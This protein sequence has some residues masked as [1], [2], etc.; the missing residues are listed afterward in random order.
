MTDLLLQKEYKAR[1]NR[2]MDYIQTRLD[3]ELTLEELAG[4]ANFSKYHFHRLFYVMT[5]ETLFQF[6]Q[7]LR[8]E[9]AA[10]SLCSEPSKPI[11]VIALDCGFSS[12]ASFAKRFKEYYGIS[13]TQ[14]RKGKGEDHRKEE[15]QI[16]NLDKGESNLRKDDRISSMYVDYRNNKQIW[17]IKME[18]E[19][20]T[21]EIITFP[22]TTVAYVRHVGPYKGDGALFERLFAA[23]FSWAGPRNLIGG[24]DFKTL[25]IYHDNPEIT[26]DNKLRVSVCISVPEDTQVSGEIGKMEIPAGSYAVVPFLLANDEYQSAWDWCYGEWLPRSGYLPDDRPCFELYP[27]PANDTGKT[28][29]DIYIPVK[30]L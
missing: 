21:V 5:G 9:K 11:T 26:E 23:L 22:K 8:M 28:R 15:Q 7:R 13:A 10:Y 12:S 19:E 2:V 30:P 17:R 14:W 3:R 24:P 29:V 25:I 18:M 20:K 1:I 27:E 6:I 4:V 16:S